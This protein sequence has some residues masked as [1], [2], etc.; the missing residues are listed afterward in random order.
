MIGRV[1]I[2]Y[3]LDRHEKSKTC[4]VKVCDGVLVLVMVVICG[5]IW[6]ASAISKRDIASEKRLTCSE[7]NAR[8]SPFCLDIIIVGSFLSYFSCVK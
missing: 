5:K 4:I 7:K 3:T 6:T 1:E 2:K 8:K